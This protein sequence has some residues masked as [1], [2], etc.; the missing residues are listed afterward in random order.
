L[1][2]SEEGYEE[3]INGKVAG[4]VIGDRALVQRHK[5]KY[6]YDLA[7]AW[8][9]MTGLPFLFAAWV[10]NKK[11][12]GDFINA[13][14]EATGAGLTHLDEIVLQTTYKE[15][16]L[17]TYYTENIDYRLDEKKKEALKLFLELASAD[18]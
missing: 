18:N 16:D 3:K 7:T 11:L 1:I 8:Q 13:F 2:A 15:Y 14:N 4:L 6:I 12:P 5:S 10:A 17:L 9:K